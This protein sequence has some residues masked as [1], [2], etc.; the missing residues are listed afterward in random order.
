MKIDHIGYAVKN[1]DKSR[2]VFEALGFIFEEMIED[3]QRNLYLQ[4]GKKDGYRIE[5]VAPIKKGS[6]VDGYL[7][8]IGATPYHICYLSE[9][10]EMDIKK[11]EADGYKVIVPSEM[12]VAFSGR[13]V[14]FLINRNIG[15]IELLEK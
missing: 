12:A 9:N 5:L 7:D 11:L 8:M 6:V 2:K 4:F 1:I 13:H 3:K 14:V 15:M 10:L